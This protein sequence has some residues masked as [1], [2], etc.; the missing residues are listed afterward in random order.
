MKEDSGTKLVTQ[1][2]PEFPTS[3]ECTECTA[4]HEAVPS[5]RNP[6]TSWVWHIGWLRKYSHCKRLSHHKLPQHSAL[7]SGGNSDIRFSL[8]TGVPPLDRPPSHLALKHKGTGIPE[9]TGPWQTKKQFLTGTQGPAL[10]MPRVQHWGSRKQAK[11]HRS[12]TFVGMSLIAYFT[13]CCLRLKLLISTHPPDPPGSWSWG[14]W[15][16]PCLFF[17]FLPTGK[18]NY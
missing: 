2:S 3:H 8:T 15:H 12:P 6:E 14:K 11:N 18:S 10:S 4:T 17:H 13:N 5:K 7:Q 1:E 9:S 16:F